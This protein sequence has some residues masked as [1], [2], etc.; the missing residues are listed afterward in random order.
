MASGQKMTDNK[1]W[2]AVSKPMRQLRFLNKRLNFFTIYFGVAG[3]LRIRSTSSTVE[4]G[5]PSNLNVI[6]RS[7]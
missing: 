3:L 7:R 1:I 4:I 5:E 6:A 2:G